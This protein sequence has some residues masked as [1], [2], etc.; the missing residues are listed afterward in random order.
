MLFKSQIIKQLKQCFGSSIHQQ[1]LPKSNSRQTF[2]E[3]TD[4]IRP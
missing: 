1:A 4:D 2:N 3:F